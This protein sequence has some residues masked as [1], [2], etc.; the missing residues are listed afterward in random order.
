MLRMSDQK[1]TISPHL[2]ISEIILWEMI[3]FCGII[4]RETRKGNHII[5]YFQETIVT[6][7]KFTFVLCY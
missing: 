2:R 3:S 5:Y 4:L 7:L 1:G 6:G